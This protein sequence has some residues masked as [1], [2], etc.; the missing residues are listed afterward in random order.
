MRDRAPRP[1]A[2]RNGR[3]HIRRPSAGDALQG[4]SSRKKRSGIWT[5][6]PA[7]SPIS[8]SAPTAP[9]C[10]RF[11]RMNSP[12]RRSGATSGPSC[13]RRSRRRRRHARCADRR[14]PAPAAAPGRAG[15]AAWRRPATG[16]RFRRSRPHR[17][18]RRDFT[19]RP[20]ISDP[21]R[22]RACFMPEHQRCPGRR[23]HFQVGSGGCFLPESPANRGLKPGS[24]SRRSPG[25]PRR[26]PVCQLVRT[27]RRSR[28]GSPK[29]A[30][31]PSATKGKRDKWDS[32]AVL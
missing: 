6:M 17:Q 14:R 31:R 11:S 8:G 10:V 28:D 15:S 4:H 29:L 2:G 20:Q 9:R 26:S 12:S 25:S 32:L 16:R 18:F 1:A 21:A 24:L 23:H 19:H 27:S 5:R 30:R 13:A 7:P 3:R 22:T